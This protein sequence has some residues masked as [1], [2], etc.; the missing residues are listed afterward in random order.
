MAFSSFSTPDS[1][2]HANDLVLIGHNIQ[3]DLRRLED[4]KISRSLINFHSSEGPDQAYLV[5]VPHNVLIVDTEAYERELYRSGLRGKMIDP[6]T[7]KLR[8]LDSRLPLETLLRSFNAS[9]NLDEKHGS[10]SPLQLPNCVLHNSGNDALMCLLAFQMLLEPSGTQ[11]PIPKSI[12]MPRAAY[13]PSPVGTPPMPLTPDSMMP[14]P[15]YTGN[16]LVMN[17]MN[18]YG[19]S[20]TPDGS[21]M[22]R[23]SSTYDLSAEFGKMQLGKGPIARKWSSN[24][25]ATAR[26]FLP[27]KRQG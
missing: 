4:M 16:G 14:L 3:G 25:L 11:I 15:L 17:A 1:E 21:F 9:D 19:P 27:G 20:A 2:T 26:S 22:P 7:Q 5:E 18:D 10:P 23:P 6:K 13:S 8:S 12:K 24:R